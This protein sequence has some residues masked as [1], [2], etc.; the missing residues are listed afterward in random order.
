MSDP[1]EAS[2]EVELTLDSLADPEAVG[3]IGALMSNLLSLH[4]TVTLVVHNNDKGSI[5]YVNPQSVFISSDLAPIPEG[6]IPVCTRPI[7]KEFGP[8]YVTQREDGSFWEVKFVDPEVL[9]ELQR[10]EDPDRTE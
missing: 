5:T 8:Q 10:G 7:I 2:E 1:K 9:E 4:G 6:K 3:Y